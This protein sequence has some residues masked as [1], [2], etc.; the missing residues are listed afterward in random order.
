MASNRFF[1]S[2]NVLESNVATVTSGGHWFNATRKAI[3]EF[4]PGLLEKQDYEKL[5]LTAVV[6]IESADSLAL[7]LFFGLVFILPVW[8]AVGASI[9]FYFIWY[10]NKSAFVSIFMT[11]LLKFFNHDA[12]QI[13]VAAIA[14][15]MLGIYGNYTGLLAGVIFFFLFK[16]GLLRLLMDRLEAKRDHAGLP[17]NDRVLKMVLIRYSI[18]ED[19]TPEEVS[20]MED[21]LK[22]SFLKFKMKNKKYKEKK[23]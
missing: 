4:V 21:H 9:A 3:D 20:N 5:I 14:L 19:V 23:K 1:H 7:I 15:S 22:E 8:L 6:W 12:F 18:Y 11:P 10:Y 13:G 2:Q 16:V 17:L